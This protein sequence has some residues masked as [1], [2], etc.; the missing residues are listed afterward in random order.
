MIWLKSDQANNIHLV[1][2]KTY[3]YL[4]ETEKAL[5]FL[6]LAY[7]NRNQA[8]IDIKTE[9]DFKDLRSEPRFLAILKKLNLG[10]YE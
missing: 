8:I 6:E 4:G 7:K 9:Y 5:E 1:L 3:A 2:H 10:D